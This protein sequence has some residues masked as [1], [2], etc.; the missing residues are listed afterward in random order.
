MN[1]GT[2]LTATALA[3]MLSGAPVGA[4]AW[5][6]QSNTGDPGSV[7]GLNQ[8]SP[9]DTEQGNQ[10]A[11]QNSVVQ[12]QQKL[13]KEGYYKKYGPVDGVMGPKTAGA[14]K[15]FQRSNSLPPS[16]QLN[17]QTTAALGLNQQPSGGSGARASGNG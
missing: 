7:Q 3:L 13:Q 8:A 4:F 17:Q 6:G 10:P 11:S 14:V 16:G 9:T 5:T 1:K 2:K 15:D 12:A